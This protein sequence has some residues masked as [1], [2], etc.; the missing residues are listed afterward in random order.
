M[1][2]VEWV[3]VAVVVVVIVVGGGHGGGGGGGVVVA[4]IIFVAVVV[5]VVLDVIFIF[6]V[7]AVGVRGS[8]CCTYACCICYLFVSPFSRSHFS[9]SRV[10]YAFL[11]SRF[12]DDFT[13]YKNQGRAG[14]CFKQFDKKHVEFLYIVPPVLGYQVCV[15]DLSVYQYFVCVSLVRVYM[16]IPGHNVV[17]S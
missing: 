7:V 1:I 17:E 11:P 3:A 16:Y 4:V 15:H 14:Y 2:I 5:A 13:A 12:C 8:C 9:L 10:F 6:V